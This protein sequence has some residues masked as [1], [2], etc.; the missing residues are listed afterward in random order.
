V[1]RRPC[2]RGEDRPPWKAR[3]GCQP[4]GAG[5]RSEHGIRGCGTKVLL[6]PLTA[7]LKAT[8]KGRLWTASQTSGSTG[9]VHW[10]ASPHDWVLSLGVTTTHLPCRRDRNEPGPRPRYFHHAARMQATRRRLTAT[11]SRGRCHGEHLRAIPPESPAHPARCDTCSMAANALELPVSSRPTA[12]PF[13]L[14]DGQVVGVDG[15]V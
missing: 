6:P 3:R 11:P 9:H 13:D 14:V 15:I 4:S 8:L 1:G 2:A 12:A 5:G 7:T 10:H